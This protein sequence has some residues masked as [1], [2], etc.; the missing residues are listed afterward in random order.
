[1]GT[2]APFFVI[3]AILA[4]VGAVRFGASDKPSQ[5]KTRQEVTALLSGIPQEGA[6]PGWPQA[7]ITIRMFAD[8]ECPTVRSF[9]V[10]YLPSIVT[11]WI[12]TGEV[13]LEYR[14]LQTDTGNPRTFIRQEVAALAA[15]RQDKM[16]NFLLTFLHEQGQEF[17][18]YATEEF[19]GEMAAQSRGPGPG[20]VAAGS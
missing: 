5:E 16:W 14:S 20:A 12:R 17:T 15:G 6:T 9:V 4:V 19:L 1:V 7:P 2:L 11:A 18:E 8:L 3:A 10:S 13:K